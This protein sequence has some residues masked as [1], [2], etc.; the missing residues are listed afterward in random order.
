MAKVQATRMLTNGEQVI[1]W[2]CRLESQSTRIKVNYWKIHA[3]PNLLSVIAKSFQMKYENAWESINLQA[4]R[5]LLR[6]LTFATVRHVVLFEHLWFSEGS[7][8]II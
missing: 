5:T 1:N 4:L 2:S 7:K 8:A 6:L 3:S